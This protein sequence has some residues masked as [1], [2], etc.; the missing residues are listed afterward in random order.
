MHGVAV[1]G[2]RLEL[3]EREDARES[4]LR[5]NGAWG[6]SVHAD[7]AIAPFYGEAAGEG[8]DA[9]FGD[10]RGND[11]SRT[12]RRVGCGDVQYGAFVFGF[13]PAASARHSGVESA[14]ENDADD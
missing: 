6:D 5:G 8:F 4:A 3:R 12:D 10:G 2:Q 9:G 1:E 14:V 7:A 13:E 11:V